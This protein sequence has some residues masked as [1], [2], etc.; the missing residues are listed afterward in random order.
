MPCEELG[1]RYGLGGRRQSR[2]A[3]GRADGFAVCGF[4]LIGALR[5]DE[6]KFSAD[7]RWR[8]HYAGK[9][10]GKRHTDKAK[11]KGVAG[12]LTM[13]TR[14]RLNFLWRYQI[15]F[16][17]SAIMTATTMTNA[18]NCTQRLLAKLLCRFITGSPP[19]ISGAIM[20]LPSC[21]HGSTNCLVS[22]VLPR[23]GVVKSSPK[24]RREGIATNFA[25]LPELLR[26]QPQCEVVCCCQSRSIQRLRVP[27][28]GN[29]DRRG[30]RD[31]HE[32]CPLR[33]CPKAIPPRCGTWKP[34]GP[35]WRA[36]PPVFP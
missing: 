20:T 18:A 12:M 16:A 30:L 7:E 6:R 4:A 35:H 27:N 34:E 11:N 9:D 3:W 21:S 28:N 33:T 10:E 8:K 36:G 24:M 29:R 19:S 26:S 22:A 32:S 13:W 25:R 23:K 14:Q 31:G 17:A 5:T 15:Y 1:A 2:Q